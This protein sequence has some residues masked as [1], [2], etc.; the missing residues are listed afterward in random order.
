L[1]TG[2][3]PADSFSGSLSNK[4]IHTVVKDMVSYSA[5]SSS[6]DGCIWQIEFENG[7]PLTIPV[8]T[9][10]ENC[11]YTSASYGYPGDDA[12]RIAVYNLFKKL[13]SDD[14]PNGKIDIN[15]EAQNLQI[16]SSQVVGIPFPWETVVQVR[17]WW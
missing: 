1:E 17:K 2:I 15:F 6:A 8:G 12:L 11:Y 5:I 9:S 10:T 16:S 14:P 7:N 13:D 4:I 3:S